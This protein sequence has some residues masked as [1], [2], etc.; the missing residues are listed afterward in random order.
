M[1]NVALGI[2][3][4]IITLLVVACDSEP[5]EN[6]NVSDEARAVPVEVLIVQRG[7]VSRYVDAV[8]T[9]EALYDADVSAETSGRVLSI[10]SD[11]GSWVFSGDAVIVLDDETQMLQFESSKAQLDIAE[12]AHEKAVKDLVRIEELHAARDISE[13]EF[14]QTRLM[15]KSAKGEYDLALASYGLANKALDDTHISAP[16]DGEITAVYVDPGEMV[17]LGQIV[18]TIVRTDT[19][20]IN[21]EVSI[22]D[23]LSLWAGMNA[24]IRSRSIPDTIFYG[25]VHSV[26]V[27]ASEATKRYPVR[28]LVPNECGTL[29]P[30]MHTDIRIITGN[31]SEAITVP[32]DAILNRNGKRVVFVVENGVAAMREVS[33]VA[34]RSNDVVLSSGIAAGE[35]LVV[36]GQHSLRDGQKVTITE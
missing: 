20:E 5:A 18:F 7:D 23:A 13:S 3:V 16:Y 9:V 31:I 11:V 14:E 24:D 17:A 30:G 26:S 33:I 22:E 4:G 2:L 35:A 27:K 28:V 25:I 15:A 8:G 34:Q 32:P 29:L 36:V 6:S 21:V 19:I 10:A 1:R 12:A